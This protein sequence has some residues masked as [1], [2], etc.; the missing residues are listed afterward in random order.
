MTKIIHGKE[1]F[2][3]DDR[4][5]IYFPAGEKKRGAKDTKLASDKHFLIHSLY[6]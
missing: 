3:S 1:S 4:K 6:Y 5:R 2:T